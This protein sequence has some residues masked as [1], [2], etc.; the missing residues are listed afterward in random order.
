MNCAL[1][2]AGLGLLLSSSA[3]GA[4]VMPMHSPGASAVA[5]SS[6]RL[7]PLRGG[8]SVSHGPP[9]LSNLTSEAD[10]DVD[11]RN[12]GSQ[13]K[14]A[15]SHENLASEV[16]GEQDTLETRIFAKDEDNE[17]RSL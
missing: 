10:S 9:L 12:H 7:L 1:S 11:D 8:S 17:H 16:H 15:L 3:T 14:R 5:A 2:L 4:S 6:S 13:M